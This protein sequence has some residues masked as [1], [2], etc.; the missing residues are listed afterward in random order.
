MKRILFYLSGH[1]FGHSTRMIEVMKHLYQSKGDILCVVKTTSPKWLF[2]LSLNFPY[3]Y[4]PFRGDIGVIQ[5]DSLNLDKLKT[6][7]EYA[8]LLKKKK[9]LVSKEKDYVKKNRI[10]AIVGDIPPIAFDIAREADIP[11]IAISNFSWDWIYKDYVREF[12]EYT[13]LI[14]EIES[15]YAKTDLLLRLPFYGDMSIFPRR[16][17][18]SL[19]VRDS[20]L[21][22]E[23][24]IEKLDL[25]KHFSLN[26]RI[27]LLSFGG[28]Y[29]ADIDFH[30]LSEL[31]D[32]LFL[33]FSDIPE[34]KFKNIK[35]LPPRF[36]DH[37]HLVKACDIVV[38]K[39]GYGIVAECIAY[40]TPLLYTSR[41][42]FAEYP[43]LTEGM[44]E[45]IP[46][47]FIPREDFHSGKWSPY[48][49]N[50]LEDKEIKRE[51]MRCSGAKEAC[52]KILGFL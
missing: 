37:H 50:I 34:K 2:D 3:E 23:E 41:G 24:I 28:F 42:D 8:E 38:S 1:G 47:L 26:K 19:I 7:K 39:P 44:K 20:H 5:K 6:L 49:K 35:T 21:T 32:Y 4:Y 46:S 36:I 40:K 43:I 9:V 45:Y 12:S 11:G 16:E 52:E 31:K 15:S 51:E 29:H 18:I 30:P 33:S 13:Y 10:S 27:V 48:L 14:E 22:K 17:D 25:K